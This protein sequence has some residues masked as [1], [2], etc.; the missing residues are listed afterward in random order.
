MN[1]M[2]DLVALCENKNVSVEAGAELQSAPSVESLRPDFTFQYRYEDRNQDIASVEVKG[3][4]RSLHLV[5]H[6]NSPAEVA[7]FFKRAAN[8]EI[9][10]TQYLSRGICQ[11]VA[12]AAGTRS[13]RGAIYNHNS[14][15][16]FKI[17][18]A[19][20]GDSLRLDVHISKLYRRS[21]GEAPELVCMP[22]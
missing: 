8:H 6:G 11:A 21:A 5:E 3:P 4:R 19:I 16:F 2:V 12:Y 22:F 10:D 1:A 14:G 18:P 7:N 17:A 20:E 13:G 15:L 9:S